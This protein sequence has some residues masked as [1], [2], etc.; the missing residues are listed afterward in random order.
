MSTHS[1][2]VETYR[3]RRDVQAADL[4]ALDAA[5]RQEPVQSMENLR[6][7]GLTQDA[8]QSLRQAMAAGQN[9]DIGGQALRVRRERTGKLESF[10]ENIALH[11]Q[12]HR[13]VRL[14]ISLDHLA[15]Y[16]LA[17]LFEMTEFLDE[18]RSTLKNPEILSTVLLAMRRGR[19]MDLQSL[20]NVL[21]MHA[22]FGESM[23]FPLGA[24]H[25]QKY[26][27]HELTELHGF[28]HD[29]QEY[30]KNPNVLQLIRQALRAKQPAP[31]PAPERRDSFDWVRH[32]DSQAPAQRQAEREAAEYLGA[33]TGLRGL[34][35][36][37]RRRLGFGQPALSAG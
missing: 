10:Y 15:Q 34:W 6:V 37:F 33:N 9:V 11:R 31:V 30:L 36:G 7:T 25:L 3:F 23:T 35:N 21:D 32:R 29:R 18:H 4:E 20:R 5:V 13:Q 12:H 17:T 16:D 27:E 2:T 8:K 19:T 26:R 14:N 1:A 24:E 22:R 28:L